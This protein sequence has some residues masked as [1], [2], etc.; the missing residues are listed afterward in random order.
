V[1]RAITLATLCALLA[2]AVA[3][4]VQAA[5]DD[6]EAQSGSISPAW[7]TADGAWYSQRSGVKST[8]RDVHFVNNLVGWAVGGEADDECLIIRTIDGGLSWHRQ[9][10]PRAHRLEAVD[11]VNARVGWAV[12]L[13]GQVLRTTDS[14]DSWIWQDAGTGSSLTDVKAWD[15]N[16]AWITV[17]TGQVLKTTNG[18]ASWSLI[19][20]GNTQGLFGIDFVDPSNGW[21]TGSAGTMMRTTD[22]GHTWHQQDFRWDDRFVAVDFVDGS[23]GWVAGAGVKWTWDGGYQWRTQGKDDIDKS[24]ED[25]SMP[26]SEYGWVVGD[27]GR[28]YRTTDR[29]ESW[30]RDAEGMTTRGLRGVHFIDRYEGWVVATGGKIFHYVAP[31]PVPTEQNTPTH[32]PPPP[33]TATPTATNTPP[34]T[35]TPT[36]SGPWVSVT[37]PEGPLLAAPGRN[38]RFLVTHGNIDVPQPLTCTLTGA[39]V[40]DMLGIRGE[41]EFTDTVTS[42]TRT[43]A[44]VIRADEDAAPGD[45]FDFTARIGSVGTT[46]AGV[47]ATA[48]FLPITV[49]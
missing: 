35:A 23:F 21:V 32:T 47:I 30:Q 12:G 27:E 41:T 22:G 11:F 16:L 7:V 46:K 42:R 1:T 44:V 26:D 3:A 33:P 19:D 10:C 24:L 38:S 29:G 39:V 49:R 20:F 43:W 18:G 13:D 9:A 17:R 14:G 15:E 31:R 8:L 48:A 28:I 36:P 6:A 45:T 34:P 37:Q 2:L 40:F 5:P 25:V 4:V